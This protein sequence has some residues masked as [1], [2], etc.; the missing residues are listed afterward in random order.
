M[1]ERQKLWKSP[2]PEAGVGQLCS[3]DRGTQSRS[4]VSPRD[5]LRGILPACLPL[6]KMFLG[7]KC[8]I[9]QSWEAEVDVFYW[10]L[11]SRI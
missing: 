4:D 6:Q 7:P 2:E 11:Y 10:Q 3:L 5:S 1:S 8:L 9:K